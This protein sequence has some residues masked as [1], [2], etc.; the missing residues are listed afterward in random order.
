M[1][2]CQ[3][4]MAGTR[5]LQEAPKSRLIPMSFQDEIIARRSLGLWRGAAPSRPHNHKFI[6]SRVRNYGPQLN[7]LAI[8]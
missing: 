5:F 2:N 3:G 6:R 1:V 4:E 7:F 8:H